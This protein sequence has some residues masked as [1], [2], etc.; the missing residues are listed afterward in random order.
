MVLACSK[1]AGW[2]AGHI[3]GVFEMLVNLHDCCLI[4]TAV[5]VVWC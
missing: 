1:R 4:T 5:A 3:Q 2:N